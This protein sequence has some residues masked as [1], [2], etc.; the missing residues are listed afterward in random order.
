[1]AST[2]CTARAISWVPWSAVWLTWLARWSVA[3]ATWALLCTVAKICSTLAAVSSRL[4]ACCSVRS[5]RAR[6]SAA[7]LWPACDTNAALLR[8]SATMAESVSTM[9]SK[10]RAKSDSS[11]RPWVGR[12]VHKSPRV[13]CSMAWAS[14]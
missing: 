12:C 9:R 3:L 6:L 10:S 2:D 11:S 8:M 7:R 13:V 5:D 14:A 4:A 1:M